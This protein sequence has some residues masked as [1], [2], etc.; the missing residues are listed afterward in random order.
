[1]EWRSDTPRPSPAFPWRTT[2]SL[3]S[4]LGR[5]APQNPG[6]QTRREAERGPTRFRGPIQGS[7][8]RGRLGRSRS[9]LRHRR[10]QLR[11][12]ASWPPSGCGTRRLRTSRNSTVLREANPGSSDRRPASSLT[13]MG[14]DN[15]IHFTH[16][17]PQKP[18]VRE[19]GAGPS[20][21]AEGI[22]TKIQEIKR[23][24]HGYR[25]REHFRLAIYFHLGGLDL[26]PD[27][28]TFHTQP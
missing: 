17:Q 6:S 25:N 9:V 10:A 27:S 4:D 20:A 13:P 1:M 14:G 8:S 5:L 28:L 18:T 21:R 3:P 11:I 23:R 2:R 12:A 7:A 24:A 26:Y 22:N 16:H 15:R 19:S